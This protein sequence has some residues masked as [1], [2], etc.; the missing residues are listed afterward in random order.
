[1]SI[2]KNLPNYLTVGRIV[3]IPII[4]LTLH[5]EDSKFVKQLGAALFALASITDFIDGYL[6][7]KFN[8]VSNFGEMFDPIADKLLVG[9]VII[10]L[11]K[12]EKVGE[13]PSMLI[14]SREF[15][16]AGLREFLAQVQVSVPVS[17]LAKVKTFMQMFSLTILIL[18]SEGSGIA[19]LDLIGQILFWVSAI[20]TIVTGYS[21]LKASSRYF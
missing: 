14:L 3:V 13:I 17:R 10:M 5:I 15:L 18:G 4:V 19:Y 7:R 2:Y 11:V 12:K 9:C 16:V 8:T 20:L 1:M 21:Y 6:A